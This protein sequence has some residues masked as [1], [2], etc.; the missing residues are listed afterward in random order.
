MNS[1]PTLILRSKADSE[2]IASHDSF[3]ETRQIQRALLHTIQRNANKATSF[4]CKGW[5]AESRST[6]HMRRSFSVRCN[7]RYQVCWGM[8]QGIVERCR[9]ML[10]RPIIQ[11]SANALFLCFKRQYK[12]V[13]FNIQWKDTPHRWTFRYCILYCR[14]DCLFLPELVKKRWNILKVDA[15]KMCFYC[16]QIR[17]CAS[18]SD[19]MPSGRR[20][21]SS[22][23]FLRQRCAN[24]FLVE[25]SFD[26]KIGVVRGSTCVPSFHHLN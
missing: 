9:L 14:F 17:S 11:T 18:H 1:R 10:K 25:V 21:Q 16:I 26:H 12:I 15:W 20:H 4:K 8:Q 2:G 7:K 3:W 5:I 6:P 22:N 23:T 19:W 13:I 24:I